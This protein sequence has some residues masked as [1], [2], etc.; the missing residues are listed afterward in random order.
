MQDT[1]YD[2]AFFELDGTLIPGDSSLGILAYPQVPRWQ[3]WQL[4]AAYAPRYVLGRAHLIGRARLYAGWIRALAALTRNWPKSEVDELYR[5]VAQ[6]FLQSHYRPEVLALMQAHQAQ[7]TKV[8]LM[9]SNFNRAAKHIAQHVGADGFIGTRLNFK[10]NIATGKIKGKVNVS[11]RKLAFIRTY[12]RKQ[13][14]I[15]GEDLSRCIAYAAHYAEAPLLA[16][17][18]KAVAAYPDPFLKVAAQEQQWLIFP[19]A[20]PAHLGRPSDDKRWQAEKS[21]PP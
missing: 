12:L 3:V 20:A 10:D 17:M 14:Y 1:A 18:G 11:P 21:G 16:A 19:D 15:H 7:G 5:W 13:A 9:T 8:I 6:D 2:Y 4:W